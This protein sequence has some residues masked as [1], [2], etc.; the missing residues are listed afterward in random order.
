MFKQPNFDGTFKTVLA[1]LQQK[2]HF[3]ERPL[4]QRRTPFQTMDLTT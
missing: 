4:R 2:D 3:G 1:K